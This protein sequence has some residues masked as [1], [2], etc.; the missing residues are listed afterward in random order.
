VAVFIVVEA[1]GTALPGD[2]SRG[3]FHQ[4]LSFCVGLPPAASQVRTRCPGSVRRTRR[5]V[6][7]GVFNPAPPARVEQKGEKRSLSGYIYGRACPGQARP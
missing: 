7:Q 1:A 5:D 3:G 4:A 6:Q 2:A